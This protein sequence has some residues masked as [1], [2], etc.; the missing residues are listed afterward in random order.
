MTS[1]LLFLSSSSYDPVGWG[2]PYNYLLFS[3]PREELTYVAL[4]VTI[5]LVFRFF[6][7]THNAFF[8]QLL[9]FDFFFLH[10]VFSSRFCSVLLEY[11]PT[12][13]APSSRFN[14]RCLL[15]VVRSHHRIFSGTVVRNVFVRYVM[16]VCRHSLC[17]ISIL[18]TPPTPKLPPS[19]F[20]FVYDGFVALF[21]NPLVASN[22]YLPGA[23][24][25]LACT[26][27]T[28]VLVWRLLGNAQLVRCFVWGLILAHEKEC[29]CSSSGC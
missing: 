25:E 5:D 20:S 10:F 3:D 9:G 24:K 15:L 11:E 21:A 22:T 1:L 19:S 13:V 27:E 8:S 17:S 16:Q 18:T 14:A 23:A 2:L 26:Q 4:Q 12:D 6:F 7:V 29:V 28:L